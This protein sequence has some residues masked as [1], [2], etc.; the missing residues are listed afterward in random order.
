MK[1]FRLNSSLKQVGTRLHRAIRNRRRLAWCY[2]RFLRVARVFRD[3]PW[4]QQLL[5]SINSVTWPKVQLSPVIVGVAPNVEFKLIPHL[6]EGDFKAHLFNRLDYEPEVF[7]WLKDRR[8]D[9]VVEIGANVGLFTAF[10]SKLVGPQGKVYAFE[11]SREAYHRLQANLLVNRIENVE[12]FNCAIADHAGI[13]EFFEPENQLS[14][15]SLRADFVR[16]LTVARTKAITL[17]GDSIGRLIDAGCRLLIKI[18][19]EGSEAAVLSSLKSVI[20]SFRP[21]IVVEILGGFADEVNSISFLAASG[22]FFYHLTPAGLVERGRFIATQCR[23]YCLLPRR[24]AVGLAN[25]NR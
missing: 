13:A 1:E 19:V 2:L 5:N 8:Y 6:G 10:F 15:C 17:S 4:K 20:C 21:D 25:A 11:P 22:Y 18:D 3:G 23:D 7:Q 16:G 14:N 12:A 24:E 9:C